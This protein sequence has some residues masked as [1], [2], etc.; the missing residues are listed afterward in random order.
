MKA[1]PLKALLWF[2]CACALPCSGGERSQLVTRLEAGEKQLVVAY[3]TSLTARGAWVTQM[4]D[5]L[6]DRHP[7]L[8]TVIN[9]GGSGQWSQWGLRNLDKKVLQNR[10]DTVFIEFSINDSVARFKGSV[11][12]AK[13]NLESMIDS[14][15]EANPRCE[16]ILMTMTPGD[17]YPEGHKSYRKDI[18]AHYQM[19]R[20]LAKQR[21][22]LLIDHYP[23]WKALQS[24]DPERFQEYAPDSI[25]P[26]A[27]GCSKV[28]TP[29]ILAALGIDS[30]VSAQAAEPTG[31]ALFYYRKAEAR[32]PS[33]LECEVAVYGGTPA[34]VTAA[35][36]AARMG[37][38]TTL[39]SFNGHVGGM[40]SGGLTATDVGKAES[41]G[42]MA[43][44][45]YQRIGKIK[46]F[47]PSEAEALYPGDARGGGRDGAFRAPAWSR[48]KWT[49]I[50]SSPPPWRR[51]RRSR[52]RC[53]SMRL[54]RATCWRRRG[55]PTAS[56][57]NPGAPTTSPSP[58]SGSRYPGRTSI[59]SAG[60]RSAPTWC[61]DDPASG[62]LPEISQQQPGKP[63]EGDFRVQAYNFRM[64]LSIREGR[65][66][67][68]KPA[69]YD[70]AA[71]DCSRASS[72][73]IRASGGRSTTPPSR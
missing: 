13:G 52:R 17:R 43:L 32:T 57:G 18:E 9:S 24:N 25:H 15:R 51:A 19:Y 55:F 44:D 73:S 58:A 61:P 46:D 34:G 12:I 69:G 41:I 23:N 62:L 28:V 45:F 16:I 37:R 64:Y 56:G 47:S 1:M 67:F 42:G 65:V 70:P 6:T 49:A 31:G 20:S 38:K 26:T 60:C 72:T 48:S 2:I 10:P 11:E 4:T 35:I 30:P 27:E 40:T 68:P 14:I 50:G 8:V 21:D 36:Q 5:V 3:G 22:L 7:G 66:P 63:G 71:T 33:E 59:S 53:S 29:V 54:T 39:L